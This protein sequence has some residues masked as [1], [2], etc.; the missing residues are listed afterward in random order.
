MIYFRFDWLSFLV[1]VGI[2]APF[3]GL[4]LGVCLFGTGHLARRW[5]WAAI[6]YAVF[7][8]AWVMPYGWFPADF[9]VLVFL[10]IWGVG[11]LMGI[12]L[13]VVRR[14]RRLRHGHC[15]ECG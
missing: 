2:A 14:S 10:T 9:P 8:G 4:G 5:S 1:I 15:Q 13:A 7:F 3:L 12:G 6:Y 11:P